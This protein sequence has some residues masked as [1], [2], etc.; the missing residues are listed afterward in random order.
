[1]FLAT[2][3]HGLLDAMTNGG[4]GLAFFSPFDNHRYFLPGGELI[5]HRLRKG[6]SRVDE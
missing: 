4:L 6:R 2:A 5:N 1:L 3:G